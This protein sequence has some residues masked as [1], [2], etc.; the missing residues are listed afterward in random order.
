[1]NMK[2]IGGMLLLMVSTFA[3]AQQSFS[4]PEQAANATG[5]GHPAS[6]MSARW[7]TCW[8]ITGATICHLKELIRRRWLDSCVTGRYTIVPKS[9]AI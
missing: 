2:P 8:G 3:C 7:P 4:T 5:E 6:R 1:M 9:A